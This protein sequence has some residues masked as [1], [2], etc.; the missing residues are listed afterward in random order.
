MNDKSDSIN[1]NTKQKKQL[2]VASVGSV[3]LLLLLIFI[4]YQYY[5]IRIVKSIIRELKSEKVNNHDSLLKE[6]NEKE[7][8]II[9]LVENLVTFMRTSMDTV[10]KDSPKV[11]KKR[12]R[13]SVQ[14]VADENFWKELRTYLDINHNNIISN[15]AQN[16]RINETDIRFIELVC[17]GFSYLEIAIT[18]GYSPNFV[19]NK[20][21]RVTK[22]LNLKTSLQDYLTA[23][24][25]G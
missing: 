6:L 11:I 24:M 10:E 20:R 16:K 9:Q 19:S 7:S 4:L 13:K 23:A 22:K 8:S 1:R 12:I 5:K 18:L 17:C 15:I 3:F 21:V 25:N 14:D 2:I